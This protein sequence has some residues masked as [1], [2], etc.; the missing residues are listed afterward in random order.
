MLNPVSAK[1]IE[2]IQ[3]GEKQTGRE[4][5]ITI[6]KELNHPN[7]ETVIQGGLDIMQ[8]FL[9]KDILLGTEK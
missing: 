9:E 6:A 2:Y 3:A 8:N 4:I 7:P 1:L 5:L